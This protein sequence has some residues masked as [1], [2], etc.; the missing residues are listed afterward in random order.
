MG[1]LTYKMRANWS[2]ITGDTAKEKLICEARATIDPWVAIP[3]EVIIRS[4][5]KANIVDLKWPGAVLSQRLL[6]HEAAARA[7]TWHI[8][9]DYV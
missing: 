5:K 7:A 1:P 9:S 6:G 4:F 2:G 3:N 8:A